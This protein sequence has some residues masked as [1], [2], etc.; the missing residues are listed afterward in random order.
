MT[1][2]YPNCWKS[3]TYRIKSVFPLLLWIKFHWNPAMS[4][5]WYIIS[6]SFHAIAAELIS[7]DKGQRQ[8]HLAHKA[9]N[10]CYLSLYRK[11]KKNADL[12]L[13]V[14]R[15]ILPPLFF[16]IHLLCAGFTLYTHTN[17]TQCPEKCDEV[18]CVN[19]LSQ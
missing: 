15:P 3:V 8:R 10:A 2:S 4:V 12:H 11:N 14:Y 6:G 16:S 9:K 18:T 7:C 13:P 17:I 19:A 5:S 1:I